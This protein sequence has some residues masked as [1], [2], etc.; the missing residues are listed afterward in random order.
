M[1]VAPWVVVCATRAYVETGQVCVSRQAIAS[2]MQH[3]PPSTLFGLDVERNTACSHLWSEGVE[4]CAYEA[5]LAAD[6]QAAR[7]NAHNL[8]GTQHLCL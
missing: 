8:V 7:D 5:G 6:A 1:P 4:Q 3:P 2:Q